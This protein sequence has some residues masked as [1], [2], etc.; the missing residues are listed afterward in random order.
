MTT[1]QIISELERRKKALAAERDKLRD[2][3]S[4]VSELAD[5]SDRALDALEEAIDCLSELV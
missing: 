1:K 3:E 2:F 5:T 4:E